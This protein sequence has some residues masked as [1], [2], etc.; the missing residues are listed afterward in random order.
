MP[1]KVEFRRTDERRYS[2]RVHREDLPALE[3]GGPGYDPFMPHDLQHLIVESELGLSQGVFGFMAA[4]GHAGGRAHLSPGEDRRKATRRRAKANRRDAKRL[5]MGE[6]DDGPASERASYLCLYEWLRRSGDPERRRR[7]AE[8]AEGVK[9]ALGG[10]TDGERAAFSEELVGRVCARMD[11][12]SAQWA[13]LD[14][15]DSL[16]VEWSVR[17]SSR[18]R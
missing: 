5:R 18:A 6:R 10:M 1:M 12:L 9:H 14:V 8:M 3:F 4:G 15:G 11:Q 13:K 2:V 16:V 17:A 7:A